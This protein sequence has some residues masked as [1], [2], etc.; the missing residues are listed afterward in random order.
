MTAV[1][2]NRWCRVENKH[3]FIMYTP[4]HREAYDSFTEAG[5]VLSN[6]QPLIAQ[7]LL[8]VVLWIP[9]TFDRHQ[10]LFLNP[11]KGSP[12]RKD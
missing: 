2:S 10:P 1:D 11:T 12:Q 6:V 3:V 8:Y 9:S 4:S 7:R 5:K